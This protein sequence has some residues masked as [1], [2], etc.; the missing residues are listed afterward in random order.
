MH[1]CATLKGIVV[2][3][4]Q[5]FFSPTQVGCSPSNIQYIPPTSRTP[6]NLSKADSIYL[7]HALFQCDIIVMI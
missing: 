4:L 3:G 5:H 2:G 1:Y 6:K 7:L